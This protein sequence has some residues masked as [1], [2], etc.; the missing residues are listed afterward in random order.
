MSGKNIQTLEARIAERVGKDLVDLMPPE[1][2]TTLVAAA[3]R[4]FRNE[5]APRI[6][7]AE[8][9]RKLKEEMAAYMGQPEFTAQWSTLGHQAA[10]EAVTELFKSSAPDILA[11]M[12]G[13][14]LQHFA[15]SF[16]QSLHNQHY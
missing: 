9:T 1:Q 14:T 2:W 13:P 15:E 4:K 10:S 8:L 5:T 11:S 12:L 16:R 3:T 6:I 7:E